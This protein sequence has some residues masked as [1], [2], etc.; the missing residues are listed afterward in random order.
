[1]GADVVQVV[2]SHPAFLTNGQPPSGNDH[3]IAKTGKDG[4]FEFPAQEAPYTIVV[5]H[6]RGFAEHLI[7]N[8]SDAPPAEWKVKPWGRIEGRLLIGRRPGIGETLNLSYTQQGNT[9]NAM[10]WWSGQAT[11]ND[12]AHFVFERVM[13]GEFTLT[14]EILLKQSPLSRTVGHSHTVTVEVAPGATAQV[15]MGG[16]G[17]PVTG[18][19]VAPA[20]FAGPIDWTF[21]NNSLIPKQSTM[22]TLMSMGAKKVTGRR[23][24]GYSV[25]LEADGSFRVDDVEAG[26]YDFIV[27]VNE[28]QRNPFSVGM[29]TG[30]IATARRELTVPAMPGERSDEPLD[31]GTITATP[32]EK[33]AAPAAT[34]KPIK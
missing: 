34:Q 2:P 28:P 23:G 21:S 24:G 1:V 27:V 18:K 15:A 19:L 6:E 14:R 17:R 16:K 22:Q 10:P 7:R 30:V 31:L 33:P 20:G 8:A 29:G 13:P 4:R 3:R 25:K 12:S 5:L 9:D 11:T 32:A 26:T